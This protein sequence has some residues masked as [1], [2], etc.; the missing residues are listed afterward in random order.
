[1]PDINAASCSRA[2]VQTAINTAVDGDR[3]LIPAGT[4][5][6]TTQVTL[7][8]AKAITIQ[9]AGIDVT[10]IIDNVPKAGG[11]PEV[12]LFPITTALGKTFRLTGITFEGL[13]QDTE[14]YNRGTVVLRGTCQDF[15]V[16]HVK[17]M[18]PGTAALRYY[19]HLYGLVD[20][21]VFDLSNRAQGNVILHDGW[22]GHEYGDG[23]FAEALYLGTNKAIYIEDNVFIGSGEAGVGPVDAWA[24]ARYVFRYNTVTEDIMANHGTESGGRYRGVRS[25]EIYNN[26]FDTT[27]A[28]FTALFLRGG[29]GVIYDNTFSGPYT[30]CVRMAQFRANEAF[31][32][33]GKCD[34]TSSYDGNTLG[35]GYPC[36]DQLG[37]GTSDLLSGADPPMPVAWPN[38]ISDPVYIWDN[39]TNGITLTASDNPDHI[40]SGRDYMTGTARPGYSAFSYPH[41]LQGVVES[42]PSV[43]GRARGFGLRAMRLGVL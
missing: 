15:R 11:G 6:W 40:V 38:Q 18:Q 29:T 36:I 33:W 4:C 9:G 21:C 43:Q 23:S 24:G 12:E 3:V 22:N 16:D 14:I 39:T 19:G 30:V 41:P 7:D 42:P 34:G 25:Y 28:F 2:D 35:I 32:P 8:P 37:C 17:F 13:A 20:H 1:M 31:A 10:T 27:V 26:T 5:T